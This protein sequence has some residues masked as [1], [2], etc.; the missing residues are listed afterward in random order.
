MDPKQQVD[1]LRSALQQAQKTISDQ[2][3][4]LETIV[5]NAQS[6]GIIV[7]TG[8]KTIFRRR[9]TPDDFKKNVKVKISEEHKGN[10]NDSIRDLVGTIESLTVDGDLEVYVRFTNGK[11]G[12]IEIDRLELVDTDALLSEK[13]SVTIAVN[14]RLYEVVKP[15]SIRA[16]PGMSCTLSM[17]TMQIYAVAPLVQYGATGIVKETMDEQFCL[18]TTDGNDK[19]VFSGKFGKELEKGDLVFLDPAAIIVLK[20]KKK[21]Q[22][23]FLLTN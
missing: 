1:A 10:Y 7:R 15:S 14:D 8:G 16:E 2:S 5:G 12:N 23:I 20:N 19:V 9:P 6:Y 21:K 3:E 11:G 4:M 22:R 13:E 17:K 18:I